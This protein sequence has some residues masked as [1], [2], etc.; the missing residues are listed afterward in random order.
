[1]FLALDATS[2]LDGGWPVGS[3]I[4]AS[5]G[6]SARPKEGSALDAAWSCGWAWIGSGFG[7]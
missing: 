3:P 7:A 6:L 1:M 2:T 5:R 4:V